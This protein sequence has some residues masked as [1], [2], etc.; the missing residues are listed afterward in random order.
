MLDFLDRLREKPV[1][2]RRWYALGF[3]GGVVLIIAI[4][5]FTSLSSQMNGNGEEK[6][7]EPSPLEA[8]T[9]NISDGYK[10]VTESIDSANPFANDVA[11]VNS[12]NTINS[13][14]TAP[15]SPSTYGE[16][17]ISDPQ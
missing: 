15:T 7:A 12:A 17:I 5:W 3:S 16:V 9:Q 10:Q 8:I 13:T 14:S 6:N 1:R 4:I 11:N 2:V